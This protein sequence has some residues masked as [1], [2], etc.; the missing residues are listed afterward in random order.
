M[1]EYVARELARMRV[2][3]VCTYRDTDLSRTHPLSEALAVLNR[4]A[5]FQRVVLRG[6]SREEVAGYI[7]AVANL[8]PKPELVDRIFEETEGNPFFLSEVVNLLTQE[9]KLTESVSDI[10]VP[11]GVR[12][13]LGR[14]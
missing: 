9:G 7:H 11:D 3:I 8:T 4:E 12:E 6:L 1:L 13:A 14:R 5:G 2:L 10:A